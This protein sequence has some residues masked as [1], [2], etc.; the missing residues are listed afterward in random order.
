MLEG[1]LHLLA[2]VYSKYPNQQFTFLLIFSEARHNSDNSMPSVCNI[3]I[4]LK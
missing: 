4:I 2:K 1:V 3:L